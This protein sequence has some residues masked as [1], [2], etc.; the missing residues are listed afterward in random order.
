MSGGRLD[1]RVALVTGAADGMGRAIA[2]RLLAEGARVLAADLDGEKLAAAHAADAR[3][4]L[5][6]CDV[7]AADAPERLVGGVVAAFGGLDIL[8]NNAGV[9]EYEPVESMRD[10][11]WRRTLAVNLEAV[12]ALCR[13]A[14]PHLKRSRSGR[15]INIA[16][17]NAFRSASGLGAYAAAKHGVAGLTK[18]LAVEL[19][20]QGITANYICPGAILTG[21]TRPLMEADP[22][23]KALF[24]SFGVL[25]RMGQ[26]EDIAGAALFLASDDAAFIT[27]HGLVVDGG[28]LAKV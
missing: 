23:L 22:G 20:P 27:G 3:L 2:Q 25:G 10:A 17:I 15:I 18:T 1:G 12:F 26:P 11:N 14:I 24:E 8:I 4:R 16:S 13:A 6:T 21:M 5:E 9:V 28:F 19:G 7:T